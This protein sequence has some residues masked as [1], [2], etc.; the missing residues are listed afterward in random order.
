MCA[1]CCEREQR[2][3]VDLLHAASVCGSRAPL[4]CCCTPTHGSLALAAEAYEQGGRRDRDAR[5]QLEIALA[6][7]SFY[8]DAQAEKAM[9]AAQERSGLRYA[10][11]GKVGIRRKFQTNHLPQL[12]C[13][14]NSSVSAGGVGGAGGGGVVEATQYTAAGPGVKTD[15][16]VG[17]EA[18]E[19]EPGEEQDFDGY[20][21]TV[22]AGVTVVEKH[23]DVDILDGVKLDED[24]EVEEQQALSNVDQAILLAL[25]AWNRRNRA[26]DEM[27]RETQAAIVDRVML[28]PTNW[29]VFTTCLL[30]RCRIELSKT[31]TVDRACMQMQVLSEQYFDEEPGVSERVAFVYSVPFPPRWSL[32]K[33]LADA[34]MQ[35]GMLRT[36]ANVFEELGLYKEMVECYFAQGEEEE[37]EKIVLAQLQVERS[38]YMLAV[39]GFIK[40]EEAW[41]EESWSVSGG[42][43]AQARRW[44]AQLVYKRGDFKR[45]ILLFKEALAISTFYP[46]SWFKLGCAAMRE[47]EWTTAV[48]AFQRVV[49]MEPE[50]FESWGNIGAV[51]MGRGNF[52]GALNAFQEAVKLRRDSWK[53]WQ[54]LRAAALNAGRWAL[55][56]NATGE[57]LNLREKEIDVGVMS[58]LVQEGVARLE[59]ARKQDKDPAAQDAR[60]SFCDRLEVLLKGVSVKIVEEPKF[61]QVYA[62]WHAAK[63]EWHAELECLRKVLRAAQMGA[64]HT[65]ADLWKTVVSALVHVTDAYLR[66]GSTQSLFAAKSALS[67]AMAK[68]RNAFEA[69]D[70]FKTLERHLARVQD[71]QKSLGQRR[72]PE[73]DDDS[74]STLVRSK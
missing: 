53:M 9:V 72:A 57:L 60:D 7:S 70:D 45:A 41:Y 16:G 4:T 6:H 8:N 37:A 5:L 61:W 50:S 68:G 74:G 62:R 46:E 66:E 23:E 56:L 67:G 55:V 40:E 65:D 39:M 44:H 69:T 59:E 25:C 63:R 52:E 35:I 18:G 2:A 27:N 54:N 34:M 48:S 19:Q 73:H 24:Q 22:G 12:V 17:V 49:T 15:G 13:L 42:R 29:I 33:E 43:F 26:R 32:K 1:A 58:L 14:A 20:R 30:S 47:E 51:E 11:T 3:F 10:I 31:Q 64:W 28:H 38:P 36:A 71:A 21:R